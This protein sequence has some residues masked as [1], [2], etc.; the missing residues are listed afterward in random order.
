MLY[1]HEV[2]HFVKVMASAVDIKQ[3]LSQ[4][5]KERTAAN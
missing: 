3:I 5:K 2:F 4:N 1:I